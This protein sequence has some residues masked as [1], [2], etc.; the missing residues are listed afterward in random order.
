MDHGNEPQSAQQRELTTRRVAQWAI[1]AVCFRDS[2]SAM[3]PFEYQA[4]IFQP[5]GS[6]DFP[7]GY[8]GWKVDG[9]PATDESTAGNPGRRIVWG[10]KPPELVL[11]ETLAFHDRRTA[12]TT[13]D[14]D[15][16]KKT[17]D[18]PPDRGRRL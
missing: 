2:T 13:L 3:T 8:M 10:C 17:T 6:A 18:N 7:Q 4:D 5:K 15:K 14:D 16:H 11:T 9:D 1:N 12:D